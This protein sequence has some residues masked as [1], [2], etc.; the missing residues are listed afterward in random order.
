MIAAPEKF[1]DIKIPSLARYDRIV[2]ETQRKVTLLA[3]PYPSRVWRH[4]RMFV[5]LCLQTVLAVRSSPS[6]P[7]GVPPLFFVYVYTLALLP[8]TPD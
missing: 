6:T 4:I 5:C 8:E 7:P 3:A 1:V 2:E